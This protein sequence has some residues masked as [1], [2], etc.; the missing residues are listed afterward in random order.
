MTG[1]LSVTVLDER[2]ALCRL[3]A[4]A[5]VPEWASRADAFLT[6]SRTPTELSIV[7]DESAVPAGMDAR[8]GYRALRV[9]GPLPLEL[10]GVLASL[11]TPLAAAA[12]PIFPIATYD[13]DYLF[14]PGSEL[15]RAVAALVAVGHRISGVATGHRS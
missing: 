1:A 6:I 15:A 3:P 14:V 10:V 2:F 7:A 11:T 4:S 13:T 5:P 8:R 9:E 12:V